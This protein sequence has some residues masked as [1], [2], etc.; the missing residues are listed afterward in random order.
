ME[1]N[2]AMITKNDY[3]SED[4]IINKLT[5]LRNANKSQKLH[6]I[7]FRKKQLQTLK[8][9]II[10]YEKQIHISNKMD[11]A[12]NEFHSFLNTYSLL[13]NDIDFIL[14]N[15]DDWVKRRSVDVPVLFTPA[16][17]YIIPEPFGVC[18]VMSSWNFQYSTLIIPIAQAIA[19]GN[20]VLAKPSEMASYSA[21]VVQNILKELDQD[22][23]QVVQGEGPQCIA[24]LKNQFDVIL[25]P[26]ISI[27]PTFNSYVYNN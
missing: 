26:L 24:L 12:Q 25:F 6:D 7:A 22:I 23:I 10:K 1:T 14:S 5:I 18:L 15:L 2:I 11:L 19:A 27:C 20:C 21:L 9:S 16:K 4:Q 3:D 13:L 8:S 17:S